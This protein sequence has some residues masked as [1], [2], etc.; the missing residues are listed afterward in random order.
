[1][2]KKKK[3]QADGDIDSDEELE[4]EPLTVTDG[5]LSAIVQ[6]M[7]KLISFSWG[8]FRFLDSLQFLNASLDKLVNSTPRD[9]FRLTSALPHHE[10]LMQKGVYPYEYMD[11]LGRFDEKE[12]P[13]HIWRNHSLYVATCGSRAQPRPR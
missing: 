2:K 1:M 4:E 13:T 5:K 9:A 11:S 8:Q 6:N 3:D 12:L 10:L 7:E